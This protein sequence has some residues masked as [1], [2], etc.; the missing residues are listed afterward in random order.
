MDF[1]DYGEALKRLVEGSEPIGAEESVGL[2][3]L[4]GRTLAQPVQAVRHLPPFDNSAMDGYAVRCGDAAQAVRVLD[5]LF[6]GD[7]PDAALSSGGETIKVMTG[8]PVPE[9]CEAVV[10]F[11]EATVKGDQVRLPETIKAGN[12]IKRAGEE[13]SAGAPIFERGVCLDPSGVA[14]LASQGMMAA[15]VYRPL[16]VAV[17]SGGDEV[18]EPW[19]QP[20]AFEIYN[21]NSIAL[22]SALQAAG[23]EAT[24]ATLSGD[25]EASLSRKLEE[26]LHGCDAVL[27]T[28]GISVGE[29]DFTRA[30]FERLGIE[31]FFHGL[32][33]KPGRPTMA[34]RIGRKLAVALPGNPLSALV[35]FHLLVLPALAKMQGRRACYLDVLLAQNLESVRIKTGRDTALLGRLEGGGFRVTRGGKYGSGMLLPLAESNAIA[36]FGAQSGGLEADQPIKVIALQGALSEQWHDPINRK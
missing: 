32:N 25:D 21:T 20:G 18:I 23:Y 1:F 5:T 15:T 35:N 26:V 22:V 2:F 11:E 34:G 12:H 9:G 31:I 7:V 29:A 10:P 30:A 36:L 16:R 27:T 24:Y 4:C 6:A 33:L 17:L 14:L 8:A 19:Q 28:G 13:L 3:S